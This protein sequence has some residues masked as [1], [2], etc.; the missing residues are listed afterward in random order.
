M[1]HQIHQQS[2]LM[3]LAYNLTGHPYL[4][5]NMSGKV[6]PTANILLSL[7]D[8]SLVVNKYIHLHPI[9]IISVCEKSFKSS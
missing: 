1:E 9:F 8:N 6:I 5:M 4:N 3:K 2:S 7:H